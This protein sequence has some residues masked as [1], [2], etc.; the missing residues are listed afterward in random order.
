MLYVSSTVCHCIVR[1]IT[2]SSS[3]VRQTGAIGYGTALSYASARCTLH[4]LFSLD[5]Q[6]SAYGSHDA[7]EPAPC[8]VCSRRRD[9]HV[10]HSVNAT[11]PRP[12]WRPTS[13]GRPRH[14]LSNESSAQALYGLGRTTCCPTDALTFV[15]ILRLKI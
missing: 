1:S 9:A 11:N 12:D 4:S 10:L 2:C 3:G 5:E 14:Q 8:W 7:W 13:Y 6:F 15:I